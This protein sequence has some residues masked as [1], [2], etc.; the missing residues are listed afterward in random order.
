MSD[1][2]TLSESI[3]VTSSVK[4]AA[5]THRP[6]GKSNGSIP[7]AAAKSTPKKEKFK[8]FVAKT[9]EERIEE[10]EREAR[11]NADEKDLGKDMIDKD[12]QRE[13]AIG[14]LN[15]TI[16]KASFAPFAIIS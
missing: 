14:Y 6:N 9:N 3:K 8:D 5:S 13:W 7:K 10:L 15:C 1:N 16:F 11:G 2:G 4:Q 12:L